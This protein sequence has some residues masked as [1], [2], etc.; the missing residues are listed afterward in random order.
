MNTII[1]VV[2][3]RGSREI[4]G[5]EFEQI[6]N[7]HLSNE[8]R[9]NCL[10]QTQWIT[11]MWIRWWNCCS[12]DVC[13]Q[14]VTEPKAEI[15]KHRWK[16]RIPMRTLSTI[17]CTRANGGTNNVH[18]YRYIA[19][20]QMLHCRWLFST[21]VRV[22]HVTN[23]SRFRATRI[24]VLVQVDFKLFSS[25]GRWQCGRANAYVLTHKQGAELKRASSNYLL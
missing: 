25:F 18:K 1:V 14:D 23:A 15:I 17:G 3:C 9:A 13:Y 7:A 5:N 16:L 20:L 22:C 21:W 11:T 2:P 24:Q 12:C 8:E 10:E 6:R 4:L 19:P